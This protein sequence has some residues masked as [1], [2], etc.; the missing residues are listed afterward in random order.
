MLVF[1]LCCLMKGNPAIFNFQNG[2]K[3]KPD[4]TKINAS[5]TFQ[6]KKALQFIYQVEGKILHNH[7]HVLI[8][9]AQNLSDTPFFESLMEKLTFFSKNEVK[10]LNSRTNTIWT[11]KEFPGMKI[12]S[13]TTN[14]SEI[15]TGGKKFLLVGWPDTYY[16]SDPIFLRNNKYC[17]FYWHYSCG[18]T[19]GSG[20]LILYKKVRGKWRFFKSFGNEES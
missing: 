19:C 3:K 13:D 5:N 4:S 17:F 1:L 7:K 6:K 8:S 2:S 15:Q 9:K 10:A 18:I 12:I 16:F 11:R 14:Y 20:S